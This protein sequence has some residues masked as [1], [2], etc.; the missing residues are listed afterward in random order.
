[1]EIK[2]KKRLVLEIAL[3][4]VILYLWQKRCKKTAIAEAKAGADVAPTNTT[5]AD[6]STS[7]QTG[8]CGSVSSDCMGTDTSKQSQVGKEVTIAETTVN[9]SGGKGNGVKA[10]YFK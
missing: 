6:A 3:V 8:E 7:S 2:N 10:Q 9:F 5:K 1:M 4:A